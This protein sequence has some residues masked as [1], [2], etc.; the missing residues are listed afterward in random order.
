MGVT[1]PLADLVALD[2]GVLGRPTVTS[3]SLPPWT[4]N[5][6]DAARSLPLPCGAESLDEEAVWM[7]KARSRCASRYQIV[8]SLR[9]P[10]RQPARLSCIAPE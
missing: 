1:V 4:Q 9:H 3:V 10:A 5:M 2:G 8:T 7:G 6:I